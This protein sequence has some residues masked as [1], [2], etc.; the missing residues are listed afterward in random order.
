MIELMDVGKTYSMDGI[1]LDILKGINLKI[2]EGEKVAVVGPSGSGKST[3]LYI[4]GCLDKPTYGKVLIDG[5]DVS[6]F[7]DDGLAE[8]RREKIGFV[9]QFYYLIPSL[10]VK[11]NVMLPMGFSGHTR[12]EQEKRAEK[13]LKLV[14]LGNRMDFM[15]S[16]LSGG[17][18]QRVAIA[19]AMANEPQIILA[20]E[21]TGNLDT[22]RG[23]EIISILFKLNENTT[24]VVV[25]HDTSIAKHAERIIHLKD[26][27][28]VKE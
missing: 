24:L 17:E 1:G 18:R 4:M 20:D 23:Q 12:A 3:L 11:R 25:T 5:D 6:E 9:F 7:D 8:I 10:T 27:R 16:R 14:G 26:G 28:I 15:P 21:P 22:K 13:L 19:R 2:K